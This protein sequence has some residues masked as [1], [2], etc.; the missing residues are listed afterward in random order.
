MGAD[1]DH[2]QLGARFIVA[3]ATWIVL[4]GHDVYFRLA[5]LSAA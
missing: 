2:A 4:L 5:F 3:D 1:P